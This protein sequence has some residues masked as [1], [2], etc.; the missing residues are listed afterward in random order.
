MCFQQDLFLDLPEEI[1]RLIVTDYLDGGSLCNA[2]R[3]SRDWNFYFKKF[4]WQD[5]TIGKALRERLEK[6]WEDGICVEK[7][8][9]WSLDGDYSIG[10]DL[11]ILET[12]CFWLCIVKEPVTAYCIILII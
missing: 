11:P 3:V 6:N 7:E 8:E 10:M 12:Q 9:Y 2:L 4:V 5:K 1:K